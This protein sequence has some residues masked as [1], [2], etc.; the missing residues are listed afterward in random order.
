MNCREVIAQ[1]SDYLDAEAARELCEELELHAA[2]CPPCRFHID[3][4]KKTI[5][6]YRSDTPH[7]CPEQVRIRLHA[8]LTIEYRKK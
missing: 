1:L 4:V 7:E 3:T 2:D 6:L 5:S 8:I